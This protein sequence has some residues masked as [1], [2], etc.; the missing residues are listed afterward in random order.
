MKKKLIFIDGSAGT[1]G[2]QV[3][4]RLSERADITLISLAESDRKLAHKRA[5]A[6]QQADV[7]ILCLPDSAAIEAVAL[8]EGTPIRIIDASSAHRT[9]SEWVYGFPELC[10]GQSDKIAQARLVSNPGCYATGFLALARPLVSAGLISPHQT[11]IVPAVSGYSGGGK[12]MITAMRED[13]LPPYFDYALGLSHKHLP[14]M[15]KHSG[16]LVPPLLIPSVG[17][18]EQ[19]MLVRLAIP[20]NQLAKKTTIKEMIEIFDTAYSD[21]PLIKV[22]SGDDILDLQHS[23]RVA[24][25]GLAGHDGLDI[26]CFNNPQ[27]EQFLIVARLDNLGK[28]AAGA[29]VQNLNIM[30]GCDPQ[31][32]LNLN[33]Q[34]NF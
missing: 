33:W 13:Q 20:S 27:T 17:M 30:L 8:A 34:S 6:M 10:E 12:S 31:M 21:Q 7:T 4:S 16:L 26:F 1:T 9:A 14:E 2:L 3:A 19:G 11:L 29:A 28:G 24:A 22:H 32:G 15:T 25:D 18:F 23:G 5:D